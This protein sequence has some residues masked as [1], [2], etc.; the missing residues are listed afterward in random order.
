MLGEKPRPI[1]VNPELS[2]S[3]FST[4]FH[5][6]QFSTC[7]ARLVFFTR[8]CHCLGSA[9]AAANQQTIKHGILYIVYTIGEENHG[10]YVISRYDQWPYFE[11]Q[12]G[13]PVII[14]D[15]WSL[16]KKVFLTQQVILEVVGRDIIRKTKWSE[17]AK[18]KICRRRAPRQ[19]EE[20]MQIYT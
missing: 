7:F 3:S 1:A 10:S 9:G 18:V 16:P 8:N 13:E 17:S 6:F 14:R 5:F 19:S 12:G 4:V 20:L 15:R 11:T 2:G